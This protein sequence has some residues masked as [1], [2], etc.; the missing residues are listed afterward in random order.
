M[1]SDI[2]TPPSY[3][4]SMLPDA[5]GAPEDSHTYYVRE[6]QRIIQEA[7]DTIQD[8]VSKGDSVVPLFFRVLDTMAVER[9]AIAKQCGTEDSDK[10]GLRR[11]RPVWDIAYTFLVTPLYADPYTEYGLKI[12]TSLFASEIDN[13]KITPTSQFQL[14]LFTKKMIENFKWT[15][16]P[17]KDIHCMYRAKPPTSDTEPYLNYSRWK[18]D[19]ALLTQTKM[20]HSIMERY[21]PSILSDAPEAKNPLK[22]LQ[23]VVSQLSFRESED[24]EEWI[25]LTDVVIAGPCDTNNEMNILPVSCSVMLIHQDSTLIKP[26][27]DIIS[28]VFEK[29]I[30][31]DR[32]DIRK[33]QD[34]TALLRYLFAHCCPF[35]RG[36]AAIGEWLERAL[37][38]YHGF[39]VTHSPEISGDLEALT[40]ISFEQ[41]R[42]VYPST[43]LTIDPIQLPT[44]PE[45]EGG[46]SGG[47]V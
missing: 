32:E 16:S 10:F 24:D 46:G 42:D 6:S 43:L 39:E 35:D 34:G 15:S 20:W 37:Y 28:K 27:L 11:D 9:Q 7:T 29:I 1:T 13:V 41:F 4:T 30:H 3:I 8:A 21:W 26:T 38:A 23:V 22:T 45:G 5:F 36:S 44:S 25:P 33:L 17:Q 19:P 18:S 31:W 2:K 14:S 40:A 47:S 12:I